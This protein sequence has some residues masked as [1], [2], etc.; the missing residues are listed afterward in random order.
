MFVF[1]HYITGVYLDFHCKDFTLGNRKKW[2]QIQIILLLYGVD[3]LDE[4]AGLF[5][6]GEDL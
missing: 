5:V 4:L 3:H 2:S 6:F 1:V